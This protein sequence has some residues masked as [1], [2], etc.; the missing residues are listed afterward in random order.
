VASSSLVDARVLVV[1]DD[2]SNRLL[3]HTLLISLGVEQ[4]R[5]SDGDEPLGPLVQE[6]DPDLVLLDLNIGGVSGLDLLRD[7]VVNDPGWEHRRVLMVTGETGAHVRERALSFGATDVV[8]KPYDPAALTALVEEL[9]SAKPRRPRP[10]A[11]TPPV[12]DGQEGVAFRALFEGVPGSYLVLD[13][14]L[15]IVAVS[16][17]YLRDTM[18]TREDLLGRAI[19]DAFPDNPEDPEATGVRNLRASLGQVVRHRAPHTMA[20][21]KY[22]IQ[23]PDGGF[24]VR[25]WCPVN[26]PVLG[27]D[28]RLKYVIHRVEDVTEYVRLKEAEAQLRQLTGALEQR[29]VGMEAEVMRRAQQLEEANARL[30]EANEAKREFLSRMSHELRTPLTAVLGFGELLGYADLGEKEQGFVRLLQQAGSHLLDL[31]NEVLDIARIESGHLALSVESVAAESLVRDVCEL[32]QPVAE[33]TGI[34]LEREPWRVSAGY[35]QADDQRLRQVLINL[36]SNAIKYNRPGGSVRVSVEA[37]GEDRLRFVVTDTGPGMTADELSRLFVPFERL[38]AA[39]TDIEGTGLGL[40]LSRELAQAMGGALGVSSEV[41]VGSSFW[42]ELSAAEPAAVEELARGDIARA[43]PRRYGRPVSVLYVEDLVANVDLVSSIL[44]LRPDVTVLPVMLGSLALELA[45]QNPPDL[46]L[47][48][49]HLPDLGGDEVLRRL[50][51]DPVTAEV[52]VVVFSAD[53]TRRQAEELLRAG[54]RAY[55]TKPISVGQLLATVDAFLVPTSE[56]VAPS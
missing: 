11:A 39:G 21:Q 42:V 24:E 37:R 52:P 5:L 48:D 30:E 7:L 28:G 56:A 35:V 25:Y 2:A 26:S 41:G 12:R 49:L 22:D 9:L 43:A 33:S 19:F 44:S 8:V 32:L 40:A 20:V 18:R 16:D 36:V 13:P 50:L 6:L 14:D 38:G 34:T 23:R 54:A 55:V 10:F 29:T 4:V 17:A 47:L 27:E 46:V 3:L 1:D 51:A 53:A 31:I 15:R 45:H